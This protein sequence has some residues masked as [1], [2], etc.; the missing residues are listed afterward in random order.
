MGTYITK[1]ISKLRQPNQTNRSSTTIIPNKTMSDVIEP[2]PKKLRSSE[3]DLKI[4]LGSGDDTAIEWYHSPALALKSKYIDTMLATPMREQET[5]TLTF[6]DISPSIWQKMMTYLD[7]PLAIRQMK[8]EDVKDVALLYDKYE[9]TQG[10]ELCK[11][12][13]I[14]YFDSLQ[15][16]EEEYAL[17]LELYIDL[18]I[19]AHKATFRDAFGVYYKDYL[20]Y[21]MEYES[22]RYNRTIFTE[23]HLR[24]VFPLLKDYP[25]FDWTELNSTLETML[26]KSPGDKSLDEMLDTPNIEKIFVQYCSNSYHSRLLRKCIHKIQLNGTNC[27]ADG[28]FEASGFFSEHFYDSGD[29]TAIWGGEVVKFQIKYT[30]R[31]TVHGKE[32]GW[33]IVRYVPN[34]EED[35]RTDYKICWWAP[36]SKN[37]N[38]PPFEGWIS[39]D[40]TFAGGDPKL[41]Y[42]LRESVAD[43]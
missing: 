21:T 1:K 24:K 33:A 2:T 14:D 3:P 18:V 13:M 17:D 32:S 38:V 19:I 12:I 40:P 26:G 31:D 27:K 10:C 9:F 43:L 20:F 5:R 34:E 6:P 28:L 41:K 37:L 8:P 36:Y 23:E 4:I 25:T 22:S 11:Y 7:N 35:E 39:Q 29:R 30:T 42:M 16:L 15:E